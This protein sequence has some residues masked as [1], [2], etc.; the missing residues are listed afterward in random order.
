MGTLY[1]G[2][3][4]KKVTT[5]E[6]ICPPSYKL[7]QK[8]GAVVSFEEVDTK[9]PGNQI[10][11]SNGN[12]MTTLGDANITISAV[13]T[14]GGSFFGQFFPSKLD[15]T[16]TAAAD[17]G[18][19]G[20]PV[21]QTLSPPT[22]LASY[23]SP[24]D[25]ITISIPGL[26]NGKLKSIT[27]LPSGQIATMVISFDVFV[28]ALPNYFFKNPPTAIGESFDLAPIN[29][30]NVVEDDFTTPSY[31]EITLSVF[32]GESAS[33]FYPT[34]GD[35]WVDTIT[36][37]SYCLTKI[38]DPIPELGVSF[39]LAEWT[40][41]TT[42]MEALSPDKQVYFKDHE[43]AT[44][45]FLP[46]YSGRIVSVDNGNASYTLNVSKSHFP[47]E[48]VGIAEIGANHAV[49]LVGNVDSTMS[50][51]TVGAGSSVVLEANANGEFVI[52]P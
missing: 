45:F 37:K 7:V 14:D 31:L 5:V 29:S 43:V 2:L 6:S 24:G 26:S 13:C 20:S 50:S 39:S 1:T 51:A 48:K 36:R 46:E 11:K 32:K 12:L 25:I 4:K 47:G 17:F 8:L 22:A 18:F 30:P 15:L 19:V 40:C 33:T 52:L 27:A 35:I 10:T 9:S 41:L 21:D 28:Q 16:I 23:F 3:K 42:G 49:T 38:N 34:V 44:A